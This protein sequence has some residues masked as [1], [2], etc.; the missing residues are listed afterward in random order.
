[1]QPGPSIGGHTLQSKVA[2]IVVAGLAVSFGLF[3]FLALEAVREST[4][5][6]FRER[7]MMA[8]IT[9]DHI[10]F[11]L[12]EALDYLQ[13]ASRPGAAALFELD[14]T[15]RR[16][17][18]TS[19]HAHLPIFAQQVYLVDR[20]GSVLLVEPPSSPVEGAN[21]FDYVHIRRVL[22]GGKGE[23]SGAILDPV[24]KKPEVALAVPVTDGTGRTVGVLA[25]SADIARASLASLILGIKPGRTGH[26]Q[27]LDGN[28]TVLA[29]TE[30]GFVLRRSRHYDLLF[31]LLRQKQA[32]VVSHATEEGADGHREI[33]A[34]APLA[35]VPWGVSVE[36]D[37]TEA[38]AVGSDLATR[39][40]VLGL[41][42][43]LGAL[44]TGAVVLRSVLVPIRSLT[45]ASERIANGD[46]RG[47]P[48][49]GGEDEVGRL[50]RTFEI[51][52]SRLQQS[53]EELDR[54]HRELELRVQQRTAELSCLFELSKTIA[55]SS[56]LD[57][58]M[59]AVVRKVAEVLAPVDAAYLYLEDPAHHRLVLRAWEGDPPNQMERRYLEVATA[60]FRSREPVHCTVAEG[61]HQSGDGAEEGAPG[62]EGDA[63]PL[64]CAPLL[65]QERVL[66]ALLLRSSTHQGPGVRADLP[67]IRAL[68]DQAAVAIERAQLA[69]EAEQ[70]AALREA[71]RLKSMFISTI[72]H[73]LQSPLGFI[74]GYA[75]TLLRPDADFDQK[76]RREFLQIISEE[77]DSL[78]ALIDDL[79]D[80]SRLE[81]GALPM[82]RQ[83]VAMGK[84]IRRAVERVKSRSD[85]HQF[86]VK[87]PARLPVIEADARR[88]EQV[89]HNL[90]DNAV[91]YSP[92]AGTI[93][94]AARTQAGSVV[95]S[96]ADQGIG[97]DAEE[98]GRV[99][100]RFYRTSPASRVSRRGA[101]LG[102]S[103]C[104]G[105]V[106][107]H[108]G[109]IWLESYPGRGTTVHFSLPL[110]DMR[111]RQSDPGGDGGMAAVAGRAGRS[112]PPR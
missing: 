109:S 80:V 78:S 47:P 24:T 31:S 96:V 2:I 67:L 95:V 19:I 34:F 64:T 38:L 84:L 26:T 46:L 70:A 48:L 69:R 57:D 4:Q 111:G 79:L 99:F 77:S 1:M 86:V 39:L 63:L 85:R 18:L 88:I 102:L 65:T 51:M 101:G 72:T 30:P 108:G 55:S 36:Q 32:T 83:P 66:G 104:Q 42:S 90:L 87:L 44:V 103:I 92:E 110:S 105:I 7:L 107:A 93:T 49:A 100:E 28:G 89:L 53:R 22:Q 16:A 25:A 35:H 5:A 106:E 45:F 54:W 13:A 71:D 75:T 43:L 41:L 58:M 33:V 21:L 29:S 8:Q 17:A 59:R 10:D 68:A 3:G 37:E 12:K 14:P 27:I 73:E 98:Q 56:D 60:A 62:A 50:A 61:P 74:K 94:V 15:S 52:R 11:E 82:E 40:V 20:N 97:I 23:I 9:A 76:T 91:K 6:V 112:A 81:A